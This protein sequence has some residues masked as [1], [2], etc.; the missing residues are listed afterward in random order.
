MSILLPLS[1]IR[2]WM[3]F[4]IAFILSLLVILLSPI[5]AL[6]VNKQTGQLPYLLKWCSTL[7]APACGD[8]M[9]K[10]NNPTYNYWDLCQSWIARNP[11]YGLL[12]WFGAGRS[13]SYTGYGNVDCDSSNSLGAALFLA[14]NGFQINIVW[15]LP[16]V[17][18]C[19]IHSF[20]WNI[21][22]NGIT[23]GDY[24]MAPIRFYKY[25]GK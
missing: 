17:S 2:Y 10:Q 14:N 13:L 9:W 11:A 24:I 7:D 1:L 5:I 25:T 23:A 18:W 16:F 6:F 3:L 21:K 20:G 8:V 15:K 19:I 22:A 12:N 4:P